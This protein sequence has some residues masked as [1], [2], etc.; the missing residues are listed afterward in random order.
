MKPRLLLTAPLL[1]VLFGLL[2]WLPKISLS[3]TNDDLIYQEAQTVYLGNLARRAN[4]VPPLRWNHQLTLAG[5]WFSWDSV[6]NRADPYCGHQDT[7]GEWPGDRA[8][9]FGYLGFAGAENAFCG[10]VTPQQAID[11]WMNS[12]GH[13]ANL[14]DPNS[15]EVGL[16][17]YRRSGD[18]RG[19]VTQGFG[20]DPVFPPVIINNEAISTTTTA[21][22]LYIYDRAGGGGFAELGPAVDMQI[23]NNV[24]LGGAA[25]QSY[26]A[27]TPWTLESGSGWR[28]VTVK[29]RDSLGRTTTVSDTI[30]LGGDAPPDELALT[31][32]ATTTDEVTVYDLDGQGYSQVQLSA[33]W[34]VDDTFGTF[35]LNWGNGERVNDPDALGGT[36]FRLRPGDGESNA[37]VW[38]TEFIKETP[39]VAYVRLK[40]NDNSEAGQV[41]R[42]SI[43]GGGVEYG[44][45]S[46]NGVDF[47]APNQYQE[48]LL[49]FTFHDDPNNVF[50]IMNFWR[51]GN[52]DVYV[53][54]IHLFSAPMP[55]TSPLTW[56]VPGGN[57]RGQGVRLRYTNGGD[58]FSPIT[59]AQLFPDTVG[60]AVLPT[61]LSF[62]AE[63]YSGPTTAQFVDITQ[64]G[65]TPVSWQASSDAAWL[66]TDVI[67]G[68]VQT[69]VESDML[70]AG[71]HTAV[72]AIT[73][74]EET[75]SVPVTAVIT[76]GPFAPVWAQ[77][78]VVAEKTFNN[79]SPRNLALDSQGRPHVVYGGDRLY[80]AWYDGA[81][82]QY[83]TA[84]TPAG[85]G[86]WASLALDEA[87]Q[88]H[89][90]FYD[91]LNQSLGYA[92]RTTTGWQIE[93]VDAGDGA[94]GWG[95]SIALD[96]QG[97][98]HIAYNGG[99]SGVLKYAHWTGNA[100]QTEVVV[101]PTDSASS[102]SLALDSA[103][104]PYI[105]YYDAT[106]T[107]SNG[108]GGA[109]VKVAAKSGAAW[110]IETAG[111]CEGNIHGGCPTS[112]AVD[113]QGTPHL[114]YEQRGTTTTLVYAHWESGS[115][116][117]DTVDTIAGGIGLS[118][119]SSIALDGNDRPF[120]GYVDV[121]W[122]GGQTLSEIRTAY[123][124]QGLWVT[125]TVGTTPWQVLGTYH[126]ALDVTDD[127]Q[128]HLAYFDQMN[129]A[130]F[131]ATLPAG[132][133]PVVTML[134]Q[135]RTVKLGDLLVDGGETHLLHT[136][137]ANPASISHSQPVSGKWTEGEVAA[138]YW[139]SISAAGNSS[140]TPHFV[141]TD[142]GS[143]GQQQIRYAAWNGSSWVVTTALN[144]MNPLFQFSTADTPHM[145][146]YNSN[147]AGLE[148]AYLSSGVWLTQTLPVG[149]SARQFALGSDGV[150]HLLYVDYNVGLVYGRWD[151]G[152]LTST[153][154]SSTFYYPSLALDSNDTPHVAYLE[155]G[156]LV[157][158]AWT[159]SSWLTE[160]VSSNAVYALTGGGGGGASVSLTFDDMD[161]PHISFQGVGGSGVQYAYREGGV[162]RVESV[163]DAPNAGFTTQ[164][165]LT[166]DG[167]PLVAYTDNTEGDLMFAW[168]SW[169]TPVTALGGVFAAYGT[170]VFT[171]PTGAF[172]NEVALTC[173]PVQMMEGTGQAYRITAVDSSSGQAVSPAAAY[174]FQLRYDELALPPDTDETTLALHRWNGDA[175]VAEPGS[176]LDTADNTITVTTNQLGT[177]TILAV[178]E[179]ALYLP[180]IIR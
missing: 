128:P 118:S 42:F 67:D 97:R 176:V 73:T 47:D 148:R 39:L 49:P 76:P 137:S 143:D 116:I 131:Y 16:G 20:T 124:D 136:G 153:V 2:L 105:A 104:Q 119:A 158:G 142:T 88:V 154:T 114:S 95:N 168:R 129:S 18:G 30:Y 172:E 89:V 121:I 37:W 109:T 91:A 151:G 135:S 178:D 65:C 58:S 140:G 78:R 125:T 180:V 70:D 51:S 103:D 177:W 45:I 174:Q 171:I 90:A 61:S 14:L 107:D 167:A 32:A 127:G 147:S 60:I 8:L 159:G 111:A 157:Y 24:C 84:P 79:L 134:D 100:W 96:S 34:T 22:D 56:P 41:A 112:I 33:D 92:V 48:F 36:A 132:E 126:V 144:G 99:T 101:G 86:A 72:L 166:P 43:N 163:D 75:I 6:E 165:A 35:G 52:A 113:N 139:H 7:N 110:S 152:Y 156:Q 145:V 5:R 155:N 50:L 28:T 13:R 82:W 98:P 138:G 63:A 21:V 27:E 115:W 83:E 3:Q 102:V 11:G 161:V 17:Y 170:A 80:Y 122:D 1:V 54:A 81:A 77:E 175:W 15:R 93:T 46:L 179:Q 173:T 169:S 62:T 29:T 130:L 57:Y 150:Y 123:L 164:L 4:G 68:R 108:T 117:S 71:T 9:A 53:D 106:F 69:W 66:R 149:Q 74:P 19:Y 31:Q 40:V 44:P 141:F 23:S 85:T 162:W 38:T 25:W 94:V 26:T 133:L 120:I 64:T 160:T 59:E 55:V 146:Y 12:D 87:G 10:Y